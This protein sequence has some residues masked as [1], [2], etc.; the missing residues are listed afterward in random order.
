MLYAVAP[1]KRNFRSA[2]YSDLYSMENLKLSL[3][4]FKMVLATELSQ[5]RSTGRRNFIEERLVPPYKT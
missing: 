2:P 3:D 1:R 4:E 5:I